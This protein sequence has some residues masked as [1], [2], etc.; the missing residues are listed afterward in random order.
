MHDRWDIPDL[1]PF[2]RVGWEEQQR[3]WPE[4]EPE[5]EDAVSPPNAEDEEGEE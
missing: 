4:E 2:E 3:E 5:D 1:E